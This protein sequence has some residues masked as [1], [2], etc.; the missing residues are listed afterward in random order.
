MNVVSIMA[1]QDDEMRC[2]GA[3]LKCREWG[4]SLH[5]ISLTDCGAALNGWRGRTTWR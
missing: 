2:L 4:D 3:M 1:H 5:F